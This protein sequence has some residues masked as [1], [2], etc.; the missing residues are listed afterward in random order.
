MVRQSRRFARRLVALAAL[1][2][3]FVSWPESARADDDPAIDEVSVGGTKLRETGGS[4]HVVKDAQLRRFAY[5]DPH[6]V[7]LAIPGVY[8]RPEDGM[9]L[10]PN[11]G[12]RGASSDRSKKITLMEDG[13]LVGPAPYSAPAAYYFPLIDR[14]RTVRVLKG[15]SA[16]V[17]GPHTVGGAVD[18]ITREIPN[19]RRGTYDL[20]FGQYGFNKQHVTFGSSDEHV[21]FLLEG[22]RLDNSGFKELPDGRDTGFTRSEWMAK[23]SWNP[24]PRAEIQN[25]I[26]LKLEY[27]GETSNETYLGVTDAD[28]RANPNRRYL[29]SRD[30]R[31]E[32]HRTGIEVTHKLRLTPDLQI[33]TTLYRHDFDRTWRKVNGF[34]GADIN[35]VLA[36]P[37][38]PRDQIFRGV[39]AGEIDATDP[40]Q[41]IEIGPNHRVFVSEG[42]QTQAQV[43]ATT[44]P[45][46]HRFTYGVRA[47]YDSIVRNHSQDGFVMTGGQLVP[48]GRPTEL[49]AV[50]KASTQALALWAVD[51]MT[52]GP[53]VV[54]PGVRIE[55]IHA[56][57]RDTLKKVSDGATYQ[58]VI[59]GVSTYWGL[60]TN[61]GLLGGVHKGFSPVPPEQARVA[62][63]EESVNFEG[64]LRYARRR[65]RAEAIAFYNLYSNITDICTFSS[66]CGNESLDQQFSAGKARIAGAEIFG[67]AEPRIGD[68]WVLPMRVSYTYTY[69]EF[70]RTFQ[71]ADPQF[72]NVRAGDEMPYV[73]AHQAT[74]AVGVE[75]KTFG[76]NFAGTFVDAMWE[77]AGRG[78]AKPGQKTDAYF[79]LDASTKYRPC[80]HVEL[81]VNARNLT[82]DRYIASRRPYGARSGPPLWVLGGVRGEF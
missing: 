32:N 60:T 76:L 51:A 39:L 1:A 16:I 42:I 82:N 62:S 33:V 63:P 47:H 52:L 49:T 57:Y 81:Y 6:Q 7:L 73:P 54:A 74:G 10:R 43:K 40:S 28:V 50:N 65:L 77:Q 24:A 75:R 18:M 34:R 8:V 68:G 58:V 11:I 13:V 69:T 25:E 59:P 21:G 64:G 27:S 15:P 19:E 37:D 35:D 66:G 56:L 2:A 4:A 44:G 20:A 3:A 12:I 17:F 30:D 79:L 61:L 38:T 41:T 46:V 55:A 26:Q 36:H 48:D 71:S 23:T 9:G 22:L 31:M 72:G 70:L 80:E 5:D 67:E 45:M 78:V 14:M 53:V 29:A